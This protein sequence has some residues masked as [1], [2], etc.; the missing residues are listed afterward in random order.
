MENPY[1]PPIFEGEDRVNGE[2]DDSGSPP[3][4]KSVLAGKEAIARADMEIAKFFY[5]T[6]AKALFKLFQEVIEWVGASNVVHMVTDNATNY[7][8]AG[9]K[10]EQHYASISWSPCATHCLNLVMKD[11]TKIDHV[12]ENHWTN[13]VVQWSPL[14]TY[15]GVLHK[16]WSGGKEDI[17]FV[18]INKFGIF[19]YDTLGDMTH[20]EFLDVDLHI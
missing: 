18:R 3:S 16:R 2:E 8:A 11:I 4:T 1:G 6:Y 12:A 5:D 15:L 13:N 9:K 7:V 10:V 14:R 19:V 17:Y 20:M